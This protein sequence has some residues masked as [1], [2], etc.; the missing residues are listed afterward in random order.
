M[1]IGTINVSHHCGKLVHWNQHSKSPLL[2]TRAAPEGGTLEKWRNKDKNVVLAVY[3]VW[4]KPKICHNAAHLLTV[5]LNFDLQAP[6]RIQENPVRGQWERKFRI[7]HLKDANAW[8]QAWPI[9]F[10]FLLSLLLL[11]ISHRKGCQTFCYVIIMV[12]GHPR[13]V[14]P[15]HLHLHFF[16]KK[17]IWNCLWML[18]LNDKVS[19]GRQALLVP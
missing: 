15:S 10:L 11:S 3:T 9:T 12:Q 8:W 5:G 19:W 16:F 6:L 4:H 2:P 7:P 13:A 14:G 1:L 18:V 17:P